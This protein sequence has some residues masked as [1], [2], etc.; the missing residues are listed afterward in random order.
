[1]ERPPEGLG[2]RTVS[3]IRQFLAEFRWSRE[4]NSPSLEGEIVC[5]RGVWKPL[6]FL[7]MSLLVPGHEDT[8]QDPDR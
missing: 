4:H 1:M 3:A 2:D 5:F 8:G 7:F 6:G